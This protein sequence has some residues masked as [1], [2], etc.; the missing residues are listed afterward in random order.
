MSKVLVVL[1][2]PNFKDSFANKTI[3][4]K[5]KKINADIEIDD[6]YQLYPDFKI[7]VKKE[8]EKL[9]KADSIVIQFPMFWYNAPA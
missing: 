9:V 6:L 5:I 1:A 7:D 8:Q 2:H 3:I 4:E